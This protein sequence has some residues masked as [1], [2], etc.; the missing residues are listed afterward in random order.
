MPC[1]ESSS[2][3]FSDCFSPATFFVHAVDAA[4]PEIAADLQRELVAGIAE[5]KIPGAVM[6]IANDAGDAWTGVAGVAQ[7]PDTPMTA[8]LNFL[9]RQR[10]QDPDRHHRS[11]A[12]GGGEAG[13]GTPPWR[14]CCRESS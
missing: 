14:A 1:V 9:Y 11:P 2:L 7:Y 12:G 13:A 5:L 10:D 6:T 4:T 8:D 3:C